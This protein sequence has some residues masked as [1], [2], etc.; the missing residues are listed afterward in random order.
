MPIDTAMIAKPLILER[1]KEIEI[2]P[3]DVSIADRQPPPSTRRRERAQQ[4]AIPIQNH[5]RGF[6]R[7]RKRHR[8]ETLDL[9]FQDQLASQPGQHESGDT[10]RTKPQPIATPLA[11]IASHDWALIAGH[12]T[13]P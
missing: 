8:P 9:I 12:L 11:P 6:F 3:I 1:D 4:H 5:R 10:G 13:P 2:A 7:S